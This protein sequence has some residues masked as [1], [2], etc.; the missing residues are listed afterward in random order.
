MGSSRRRLGTSSRSLPLPASGASTSM[1]DLAA[2][3]PARG[4][5]APVIA[6]GEDAGASS[7]GVGATPPYDLP[8]PYRHHSARIGGARTPS[9]RHLAILEAASAAIGAAD[10]EDEAEEVA[11]ALAP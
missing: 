11:A 10:A 7:P 9:S 8:S 2:G 4:A 3:T 6:A 5:A 1:R